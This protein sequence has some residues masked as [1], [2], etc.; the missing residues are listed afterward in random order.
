SGSAGSPVVDHGIVYVNDNR[1]I[2]ALDAG[3]GNKLWQTGLGPNL[4][5]SIALAKG[6]IYGATQ[7]FLIWNVNATTGSLLKTTDE[8]YGFSAAP[9]VANGVLYAASFNVVGAF[10][11]KSGKPLWSGQIDRLPNVSPVVSNGRVYVADG[12]LSAFALPD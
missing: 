7:D 2:T 8:G 12:T 1:S 4:N 5:G 9:A 11:A 10:D 3:T 6:H